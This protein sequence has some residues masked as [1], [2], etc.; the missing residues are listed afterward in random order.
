MPSFLNNKEM[1][2]LIIKFLLQ[3][4]DKFSKNMTFG[5]PQQYALKGQKQQGKK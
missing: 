2:N 1:T 5:Y 4:C 3:M